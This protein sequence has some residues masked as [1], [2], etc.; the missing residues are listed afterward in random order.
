MELSTLQADLISRLA[1]RKITAT[2]SG[3]TL[4]GMATVKKLSGKKQKQR[5]AIDFDDGATLDGPRVSHIG[6]GTYAEAFARDAFFESID[7]GQGTAAALTYHSECKIVGVLS[8]ASQS[9]INATA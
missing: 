9:W 8:G 4:T 2:F 1:A 5:F 7:L 3:S 6:R